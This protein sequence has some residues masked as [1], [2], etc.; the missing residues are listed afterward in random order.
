MNKEFAQYIEPLKELLEMK[1]ALKELVGHRSKAQRL[2]L[3]TKLF[4]GKL[5]TVSFRTYRGVA[6]DFR[7]FSTG[8]KGIKNQDLVAQALVEF[9]EKYKHLSTPSIALTL[10]KTLSHSEETDQIFSKMIKII[11]GQISEKNNKAAP[12]IRI[13]DSKLI[14]AKDF[15]LKTDDGREFSGSINDKTMSRLRAQIHQLMLEKAK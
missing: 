13:F 2:D 12:Q 15:I 7:G 11:R 9:M 14:G 3:N 5:E 6:E 10:G 4:H 1:S 8:F